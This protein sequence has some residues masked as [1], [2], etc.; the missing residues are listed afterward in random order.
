MAVTKKFLL[1]YLWQQDVMMEEGHNL[2]V[3]WI[4]GGPKICF[5]RHDR[6]EVKPGEIIEVTVAIKGTGPRECGCVPVSKWVGKIPEIVKI[7]RQWRQSFDV[8]GRPDMKQKV[9]FVH[10]KLKLRLGTVF[11]ESDKCYYVCDT[12]ANIRRAKAVVAR[13]DEKSRQRMEKEVRRA[14]GG[15]VCDLPDCSRPLAPWV[16]PTSSTLRRC[17]VHD[18]RQGFVS[19]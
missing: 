4:G 12:K 8:P 1:H 10:L 11:K 2:V 5:P 15:V 16:D 17:R 9:T 3:E 19:T 7:G 14:G 13:A 18:K 6:R